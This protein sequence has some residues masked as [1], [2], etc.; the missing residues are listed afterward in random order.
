MSPP[1]IAHAETTPIVPA[2]AIMWKAMSAWCNKEDSSS[3]T[4]EQDGTYPRKRT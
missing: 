2:K 4:Q 1:Q 3:K